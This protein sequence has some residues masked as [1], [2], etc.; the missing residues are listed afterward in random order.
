MPVGAGLAVRVRVLIAVRVRVSAVPTFASLVPGYAGFGM[1]L[2][3]P[4]CRSRG[5]RCGAQAMAW[6]A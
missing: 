5:E 2:A 6:L 4:L 3:R 1:H